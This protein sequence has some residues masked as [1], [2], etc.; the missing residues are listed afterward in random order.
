M[1]KR[2]QQ[3]A[4]EVQRILGEAIQYEVKDPRVGFATVVGVEISA[5]LQHA[6]VRISVMGDP[7]QQ[8][9]T[10]RA[11]EHAKGYLRRQ[12]AQGLRHMRSVPELRL[13]LDSSLAYSQHID[14]LLYGI[15]AEEQAQGD[16]EKGDAE[17]GDDNKA[18]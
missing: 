1:S 13:V 7:E 14:E 3:V 17:K 18:A 6:K 9:E 12:V 10:M 16:E 2:T 15:K 11:L 5:D 4:D 8:Q